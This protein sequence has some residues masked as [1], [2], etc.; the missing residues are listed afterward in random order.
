MRLRDTPNRYP[1]P[2]EIF[3]ARFNA[4]I[5]QADA[6][7]WL[8]TTGRTWQQWESGDR[9]M[10]PAFFDL[11]NRKLAD[12]TAKASPLPPAF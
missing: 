1:T 10:H 6:A 5:S 8:Y 11:F 12:S 7:A 3:G 9:H 4:R 2:D